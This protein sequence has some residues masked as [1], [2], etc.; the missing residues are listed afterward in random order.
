MKHTEH[1]TVCVSLN[2]VIIILVIT[3]IEKVIQLNAVVETC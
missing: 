2:G 1:L 3:V